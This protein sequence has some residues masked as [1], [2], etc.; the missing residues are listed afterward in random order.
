MA[1]PDH[2]AATSDW[3]DSLIGKTREEQIATLATY[4][5]RIEYGAKVEIL[6]ELI[7]PD[8]D[9][10][11]PVTQRAKAELA[12]LVEPPDYMAN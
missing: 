10:N 1:Y 8:P 5:R 6:H 12:R 4:H 2:R 11:D 3:V 7:D 9:A